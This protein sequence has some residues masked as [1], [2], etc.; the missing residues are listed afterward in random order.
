MT[1]TKY[2]IDKIIESSFELSF[3]RIVLGYM[4]YSFPE[5]VR[6]SQYSKVCLYLKYTFYDVYDPLEALDL[7]IKWISVDNN[8]SLI[9]DMS[10]DEVC[11]FLELENH[12]KQM[13]QE[14]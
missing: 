7:A 12:E 9:I 5:L 1:L 3:Y 8:A 13:I 6:N 4:P 11:D 10:L 14:Y 2:D